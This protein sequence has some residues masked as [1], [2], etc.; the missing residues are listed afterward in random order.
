VRVIRHD[1]P[2]TVRL[3]LHGEL[4]LATAGLL[5]E[6]VAAVLDRPPRRLVL[7]VAGLTFC[8]SAGIDALLAARAGAR[9]RDVA[10]EVTGARGIVR[11]TMAAT[12]VLELPA[13]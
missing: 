3:A 13:G 1:G 7:D 10:V 11:R 2:G 6:R 9:A 8:D 4:D 5:G 12:G